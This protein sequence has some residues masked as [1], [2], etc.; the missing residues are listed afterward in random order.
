MKELW[1][2]LVPVKDRKGYDIPVDYHR[3]WDTKIRGISGGLT[4]FPPAKGEWIVPEAE[5]VVREPMI[6]VRV[7]CT[8]DEIDEIVDI[9]IAHY[10]QEAVLAYRLSSYTI[11][12]RV[13]QAP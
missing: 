13:K 10:R 1:E 5:V 2:I 7:L 3:L 12:R 6:P 11:L 8:A 9:T 4:I